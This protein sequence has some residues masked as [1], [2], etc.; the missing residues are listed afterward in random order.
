MANTEQPQRNAS[1]EGRVIFNLPDNA[2]QHV[3]SITLVRHGRTAYNAA[4]RLQG[5]I[6]IPL[7]EVGQWQIK[8]T[9]QALRE[10]YVER[11]HGQRKQ[12]VI[13]SDLDRAVDTAH[14]FADPLGLSVHPEARV[15]ERNFGEW[16]GISVEELRERY[17]EDFRLWAE[18]RGGEMKYG[19]EAK[20]AVGAR[21]VEALQDWGSKAGDDTD[22][23]VFS[24]GA[25]I[26]QTLQTLL[27]LDKIEADFAGI[28]SMRNAHWARLI[29]MVQSGSIRWRLM[30][31]NHGPAIADTEYWEHPQL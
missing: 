26:S 9:A 27:G 31:Y 21:G 12:L 3:H 10:L 7:D 30:D 25:W 2:P 18:H 13:C 15:R 11:Y 16:E 23:Y 20:E 5:Q 24:H 28:L 6:D 29:P 8:Q 1:E 17:P 4:H 22:L 19:A 14:A